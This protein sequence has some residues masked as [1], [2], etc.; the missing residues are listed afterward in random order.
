[1]PT[2]LIILILVSVILALNGNLIFGKLFEGNA[3]HSSFLERYSGTINDIDLFN[4]SNFLGIGYT[5]FGLQGFGSS[6]GITSTFAKYGL[7]FGSTILI[8]LIS[9]IYKITKETFEIIIYILVF[10]IMLTTEAFMIKPLFFLLMFYGFG[11]YDSLNKQ[12]EEV[13]YV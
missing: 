6:N 5:K 2:I 13:S 9:F 7:I 12:S 8:G 11:F 10:V 1:L 3:S 4:S